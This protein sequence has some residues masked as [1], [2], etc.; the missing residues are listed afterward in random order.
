MNMN[1][2]LSTI[3][4]L[5]KS[6]LKDYLFKVMINLNKLKIKNHF[7][8]SIKI[9]ILTEDVIE[10]IHT[11]LEN[12]D[13]WIRNYNLEMRLSMKRELIINLAEIKMM[14]QQLKTN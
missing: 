7:D 14:F 10:D 3:L 12:M 2:L 4:M 9:N 1:L 5:K 6:L 11:F 8:E 13:E